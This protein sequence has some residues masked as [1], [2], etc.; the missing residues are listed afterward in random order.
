MHTVL[1]L[2][3]RLLQVIPIRYENCSEGLG[4]GGDVQGKRIW[5]NEEEGKSI[6]T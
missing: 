5:M 3:R 4:M 2:I 1:K 6:G